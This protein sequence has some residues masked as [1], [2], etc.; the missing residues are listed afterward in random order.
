M[1]SEVITVRTTLSKRLLA[2]LEV[3]PQTA[4]PNGDGINDEIVF[5]FDLLQITGEVPLSLEVYDLSGRLRRVIYEGQQQSSSLAF[6]WDGRDDS[7]EL[8]PPGLYV[9]RLSIEAEKG[10]DQQVGT[11][12]IVY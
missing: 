7:M 2:D 6:S 9:Y 3:S 4:T 5:S 12:G 8:V 1:L 10:E 11:I